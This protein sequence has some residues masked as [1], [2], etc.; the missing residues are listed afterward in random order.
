MY[1]KPESD[2]IIVHGVVWLFW[3]FVN[4]L[5]RNQISSYIIGG[6]HDFSRNLTRFDV[7]TAW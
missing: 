6:G 5:A 1:S 3:A 7:L 4:V 2:H